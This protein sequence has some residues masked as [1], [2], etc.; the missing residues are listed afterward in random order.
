MTL[1][2][3]FI[4]GC[5]ISDMPQTLHSVAKLDVVAGKREIAGLHEWVI[6]KVDN[7]LANCLGDEEELKQFLTLYR[8][9][10]VWPAR[11]ML[12][13]FAISFVQRNLKTLQ[14]DAVFQVLLDNEPK[15]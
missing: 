3:K 8:F 5:D 11:D 13:S 15:L 14:G 1:A 9:L 6:E 2:I 10:F 4:Y 7:L 12:S